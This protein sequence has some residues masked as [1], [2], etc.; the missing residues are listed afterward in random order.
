VELILVHENLRPFEVMNYGGMTFSAASDFLHTVAEQAGSTKKLV[1]FNRFVISL[2]ALFM[3]V[4]R[5]VK[6]MLYL[7]ENAVLL[8]DS[9][10]RKLFP[11]FKPT[12]PPVAVTET[13]QWF[14]HHRLKK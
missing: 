6:E 11:N 2:L 4:M 9:K 7:F 1:V 8:D 3:P 14:S 13:L 5:E 12:P 10:V